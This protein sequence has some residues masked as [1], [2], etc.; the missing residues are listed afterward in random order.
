M[1][2][3]QLLSEPQIQGVGGGVE[4]VDQQAMD[5]DP[6]VPHVPPPGGGVDE[7]G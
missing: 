1:N 3:H 6:P 5:F 2:F 7:V 4:L